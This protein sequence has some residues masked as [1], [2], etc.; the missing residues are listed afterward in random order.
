MCVRP[1]AS[2]VRRAVPLPPPQQQ[3]RRRQQR[4]HSRPLPAGSSTE[5]P[6]R[7]LPQAANAAFLLLTYATGLAQGGQGGEE[8]PRV[9]R[10]VCKTAGTE[11]C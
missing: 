3:Q 4:R 1:L 6:E 11:R 9:L 7:S 10:V 5:G 8:E 2:A